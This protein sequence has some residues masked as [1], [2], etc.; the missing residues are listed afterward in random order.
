M[1]VAAD[2]VHYFNGTR[3]TA[4]CLGFSARFAVISQMLVGQLL[5]LVDPPVNTRSIARGGPAGAGLGSQRSIFQKKHDHHRCQ[6][7][8]KSHQEHS[9]N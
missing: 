5:G 7:D 1:G 2:Y 6:Q 3:K 4:A 9:R 8:E